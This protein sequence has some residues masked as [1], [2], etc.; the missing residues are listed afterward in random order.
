V[1]AL[2]LLNGEHLDIQAIAVVIAPAAERR[3]L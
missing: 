2:R 1:A 3:Q